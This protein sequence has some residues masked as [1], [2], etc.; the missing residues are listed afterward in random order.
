MTTAE[1]RRVDLL[2]LGAGFAGLGAGVQAARY[3]LDSLILESEAAV[4]GL[5]RSTTVH[6]C[7]FDYGPKV[8]VL[9]DSPVAGE[10][11]D[12]LEGNHER[13]PMVQQTYLSGI[14]LVG[15]PVQRYLVDLPDDERARVLASMAEAWASADHATNYRDWLIGQFG[16]RLCEIV[17]FP[18]EE[19]KWQ[20]P[21]VSLG[22]EW[23]LKRP[24]AVSRQEILAGART[25]LP[26]SGSYY[27]PKTGSIALLGEA[28][29]RQ[30]GPIL[31]NC[32]VTAVDL[33]GRYVIASGTRFHYRWLI[34]TLPLDHMLEMTG[35]LPPGSEDLLRWLGVQV[36]NLVFAKTQELHGTAIHFPERDFVFR[37]VS[38][39]GN[40]C[41]A[42]AR[43]GLTSISVEVSPTS[44]N[45]WRPTPEADQ[46]E[47]VLRDLAKVDQFA[48]LGR[49]L[50][51]Q[52]LTLD[53]AYP[54]QHRELRSFVEAVHVSHARLGVHHCGRG[55]SFQY[56]N[57]DAA[58][59]QGKQAIRRAL[60]TPDGPT[61]TR[62][63]AVRRVVG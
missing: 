13:Y 7:D 41:P 57:S 34:S 31:L 51:Y 30:A 9:D 52:V 40:L 36:F 46:L 44:R 23:A 19:K 18:Y 48:R 28:I 20:L 43:E 24:T 54:L 45:A 16:R 14:G 62:R 11:L 42:L 60:A 47:I 61:S 15:F 33:P 50:D 49:P 35:G 59:A 1:G 12:F 58:Y 17:L 8:L 27:Y 10:L 4:G 22:H 37:R 3:G 29:A 38:V 32:T 53:R 55:G 2:I 56:C 21:L 5:C 39:L 25:R 6:G 63:A 26:P